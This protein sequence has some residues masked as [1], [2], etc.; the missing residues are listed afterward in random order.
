MYMDNHLH[1][2]KC[3][4]PILLFFEIH[5]TYI[6]WSSSLLEVSYL[7]DFSVGKITRGYVDSVVL[8]AGYF[9]WTVLE[10]IIFLRLQKDTYTGNLNRAS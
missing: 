10:R 4:N 2:K 7:A 9:S 6:P 3:I 1:A 5:P 8:E